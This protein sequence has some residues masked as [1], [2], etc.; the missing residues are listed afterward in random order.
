MSAAAS[1]GQGRAEADP[2]VEEGGEGAERRA[3]AVLGDAADDDQRERGVEQRE[4]GAHRQ[5]A[6]EGDG[7]AVGDGDRRQADRLDQRRA[8]PPPAPGPTRSGRSPPIRR[9]RTTIVAK[10]PN[11]VAPWPTPRASRWRTT[12]AATVA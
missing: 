12:K 10:A 9:V 7:E 6:G 1:A 8:R 11:T 5:R 3:A 4:G 2:G